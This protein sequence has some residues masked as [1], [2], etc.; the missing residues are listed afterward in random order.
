MTAVPVDG[1]L[2]LHEL[3]GHTATFALQG[4]AIRILL[5]AGVE[6]TVMTERRQD[7]PSALVDGWDQQ[8]EGA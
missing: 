4:T 2:G 5:N 8:T 7:T 6:S 1:A 3:P